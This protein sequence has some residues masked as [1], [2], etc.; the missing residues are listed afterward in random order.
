MGV[1]DAVTDISMNLGQGHIL[2]KIKIFTYAFIG[3]IMPLK[4]K[5]DKKGVIQG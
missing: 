4:T 2:T 1:S 3:Y 5:M